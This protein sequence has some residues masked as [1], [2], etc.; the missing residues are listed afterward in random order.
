VRERLKD[1]MNDGSAR[2]TD[3]AER[4]TYAMIMPALST[5]MITQR[6]EGASPP[7]D[8]TP[9]PGSTTVAGNR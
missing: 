6:T 3:N 2:G 7:T 5:L 8:L 9:E 1:L 4:D